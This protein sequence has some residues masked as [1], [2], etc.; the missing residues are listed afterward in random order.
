MKRTLFIS[1]LLATCA[2]G[3]YRDIYLSLDGVNPAPNDVNIFAGETI[4]L[5]IVSPNVPP[6][7]GYRTWWG[8]YWGTAWGTRWGNH[9]DRPEEQ[10]AMAL[11]VALLAAG[12]MASV[13]DLSFDPC[14]GTSYDYQCGALS[15]G[16]DDFGAGAHFYT[17]IT[18]IGEFLD[19]FG[20]EILEFNVDTNHPMIDEIVFTIIRPCETPLILTIA[21][22]PD[23]IGVNTTDP[24]VGGY[25]TCP[26]LTIPLSASRFPHCP[27]VYKFH[28]WIGDVNDPC[29]ADTFIIT[30]ANE[31]VTAV[32]VPD[33]RECGDECHPILQGDL[34]EDCYTNFDDFSIY[35]DTWLACTHPD[36]D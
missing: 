23:D 11:P 22:E 14:Y 13:H 25:Q 33:K 3:G 1:L 17:T 6:L 31:T 19:K 26:G 36:C 35:A 32:F 9:W 4:G 5:Y 12:Q 18:A 21:A 30:D 27:D 28:H 16:Y 24:P 10:V 34:N 2:Y 8:T 7:D 20:V 29:S 15:S